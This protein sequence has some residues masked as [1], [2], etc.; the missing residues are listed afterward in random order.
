MRCLRLSNCIWTPAV[1]TE[2]A[3]QSSSGCSVAPAPVVT[4]CSRAACPL[5]FCRL[6]S[7][8]IFCWRSGRP[9]SLRSALLARWSGSGV[10][11]AA[12][13]QKVEIMLRKMD[14]VA[15]PA[16]NLAKL[17]SKDRKSIGQLGAARPFCRKT[18]A[19]MWLKS[20]W[21]SLA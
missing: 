15:T 18:F 16:A 19:G 5:A 12:T 13:L 4:P 17:K 20:T 2:V 11:T 7:P 14:T 9:H 3:Q 10:S 21:Q 1:Y 6:T 8:T